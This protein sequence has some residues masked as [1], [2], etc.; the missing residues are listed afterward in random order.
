MTAP[1]RQRPVAGL[2]TCHGRRQ[3]PNRRG[4]NLI[5][6]GLDNPIMP[7]LTTASWPDLVRLVMTGGL[8]SLVTAATNPVTAATN[9]VTAA[10]NPVTAAPPAPS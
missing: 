9:L 5:V 8:D 4:A 10:T 2:P 3:P 6:A 7:A 1:S